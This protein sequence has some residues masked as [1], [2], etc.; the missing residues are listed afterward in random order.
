MDPKL[1]NHHGWWI[2]LSLEEV[3]FLV[4]LDCLARNNHARQQAAKELRIPLRRLYRIIKEMRAAGI[5]VKM[6]YPDRK[7]NLSTKRLCSIHNTV[8]YIHGE[9]PKC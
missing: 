4:I 7:H 6:F 5:E 1:I 3:E 9:C 2:G 8:Y